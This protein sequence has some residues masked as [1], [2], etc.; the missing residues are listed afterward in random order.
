MNYVLF[1]TYP[2]IL[3]QQ[4]IQPY[5]LIIEFSNLWYLAQSFKT[6]DLNIFSSLLLFSCI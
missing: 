3:N 4:N 2:D 5:I 6:I 1:Y